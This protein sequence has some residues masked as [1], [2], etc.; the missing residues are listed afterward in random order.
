MRNR[1]ARLLG[2]VFVALLSAVS[3]GCADIED[4]MSSSGSG[5]GGD[6]GSSTSTGQGGQKPNIGPID[7][8][9]GG[10]TPPSAGSEFVNGNG[11][12][13]SGSYRM[14]YTIGAP[15][16]QSVSTSTSYRLQSGPVGA[17]WSEQ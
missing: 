16:G 13:K 11:A 7:G 10:G 17:A 5:A 12:S 15:V 6:S 3:T 14:E 8:D 2:I 1:R 4:P 9:T